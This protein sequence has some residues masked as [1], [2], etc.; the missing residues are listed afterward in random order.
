MIKEFSSREIK[1][2]WKTPSLSLFVQDLFP[3]S[4]SSEW[5]SLVLTKEAHL[6]VSASEGM[7]GA[8]LLCRADLEVR[9]KHTKFPHAV[10]VTGAATSGRVHR[11]SLE[12][13]I[14]L[15]CGFPSHQT[16]EAVPKG[17][18]G[19]P[20]PGRC[21]GCRGAQRQFCDEGSAANAPHGQ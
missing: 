3:E 5:Q 8:F 7:H 12:G 4:D 18:R 16:V 11:L 9:P 15:L 1:V 2:V 19:G 13:V 17:F 20:F 14:P 10:G 21:L 6:Q